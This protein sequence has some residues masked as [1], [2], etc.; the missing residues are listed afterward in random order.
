MVKNFGVSVK[1]KEI[2]NLEGVKSITALYLG[3]NRISEIKNLGVLVNLQQIA[4]GV[5]HF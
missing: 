3:K 4:L 5:I 2:E 1:I